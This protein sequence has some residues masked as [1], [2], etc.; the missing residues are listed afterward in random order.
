MLQYR[1]KLNIMNTL[2]KHLGDL[3]KVIKCVAIDIRNS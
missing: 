1:I 2:N 3:Y